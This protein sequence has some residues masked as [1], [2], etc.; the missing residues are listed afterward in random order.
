MNQ[1]QFSRL[2]LSQL[3]ARVRHLSER[4][5]RDR[6]QV[7]WLEGVRN[8]VHACDA[9][10]EF[11]TMI[12]SPILLKCD[13]ADMLCRR[14]KVAGDRC[15]KV[16][17]EQF[18]SISLTDR[19][20]GVGAIAKQRWYKLADLNPAGSLGFIVLESI[21]SAGNLG[22]LLRTAEAVQASAVIFLDERVDPFDPAT[23]RASM[24]GIMSIPLVR[25]NRQQ[26]ADWLRRHQLL[27]VG[28]SPEADVSWCEL[29]I[30]TSARPVAIALGEERKGL[31]DG[32]GCNVR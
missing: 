4:R 31:S 8:F 24:G 13:L 12:Y 11:D 29:P 20:S 23:V 32:C 2:Q 10:I 9:G 16:S 18:R 27:L 28:M 30:G 5:A 25:S 17:P 15:V 26:F 19:A 7:F 14:R 22:T 3:L 1:S 6:Q 21:R